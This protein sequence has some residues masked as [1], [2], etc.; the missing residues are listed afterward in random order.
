VAK[1]SGENRPIKE[2]K[3]WLIGLLLVAVLVVSGCVS[4][5]TSFSR[6]DEFC[7]EHDFD[8]YTFD[9]WTD[10]GSC[11]RI[12]NETIEKSCVEDIC[13]D[14]DLLGCGQYEV[15]FSECDCK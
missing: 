5:D 8:A 9:G 14:D 12:V 4:S 11:I 1:I 6:V 3:E 13:V 15:Y 2:K 10:C 7:N